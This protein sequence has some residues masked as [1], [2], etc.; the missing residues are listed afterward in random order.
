MLGASQSGGRSS[1]RLLRAVRDAALI[2]E[3]RAEAAAVVGSD[4]A[5][6]GFPAL[7]D[8]VASWLD[9]E[10]EAFLERG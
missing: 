6:A 3:A 5:L 1:L 7:A 8:A 4:A 9:P 2:D 10:R